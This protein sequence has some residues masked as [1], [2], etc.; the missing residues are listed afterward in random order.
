LHAMRGKSIAFVGDSLARNHFKSLLCILSQVQ[1][2]LA[3]SSSC[4]VSD[5][6]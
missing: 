6:S 1:D 2:R 4:S 3:S 5:A